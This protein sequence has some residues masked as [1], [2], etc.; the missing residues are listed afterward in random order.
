[1]TVT[2]P[3]STDVTLANGLAVFGAHLVLVRDG[4]AGR[5]HALTDRPRLSEGEPRYLF[6]ALSQS[7]SMARVNLTCLPMRRHGSR[8][9]RTAS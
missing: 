2:L 9:P 7:S 8:P 4:E 3:A 5:Q 1:M 6:C